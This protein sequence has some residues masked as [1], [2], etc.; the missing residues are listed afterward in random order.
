VTSFAFSPVHQRGNTAIPT[1]QPGP[2][3]A[4]GSRGR[5]APPAFLPA[6]RR[7]VLRAGI[8]TGLFG[9]LSAQ[10][11][12]AQ[13]MPNIVLLGD[14]TLDNA[15]YVSAGEH[16]LAQLD[17][18]LPAGWRATLLAIDGDVIGGIERQL[19]RTPEDASHLIISVGGNDALRE[20]A[21]CQPA[22]APL[23]KRWSAWQW[24]ASVS[25]R[26]T[27]PCL[28][29]LRRESC[30]TAICTIYEAAFPDPASRRIASTAL[31]VLNDVITREAASRGLPLI[32]LR[33]IFNDPADYANAIEP[34]AEG[35]RKFAAAITAVATGHDFAGGRS[36]I[37]VRA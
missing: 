35:G 27:G 18:V 20:S 6:S 34:S 21:C 4:A 12:E 17:R 22:P 36:T 31:A 3:T 23:R 9:F 1:Y 24:C 10:S 19:Q 29:R 16:V 11:A 28:T 14:S 32:D 33:V 5:L 13:T 2:V 15:S 25:P 8:I 7:D 30:P 26:T 37:F